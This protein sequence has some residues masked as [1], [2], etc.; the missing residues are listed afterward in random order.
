MA[1]PA[2]DI[3]RSPGHEQREE[4]HKGDADEMGSQAIE[5]GDKAVEMAIDN[6]R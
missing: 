6:H 4:E 5:T 3:R 2:L 1:G